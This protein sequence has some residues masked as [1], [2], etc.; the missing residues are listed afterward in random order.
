MDIW[1]DPKANNTI[2]GVTYSR[3]GLLPIISNAV[4]TL[5]IR[6]TTLHP[7]DSLEEEY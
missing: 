4:G 5:T 1:H 7:G 6:K 2:F 3:I